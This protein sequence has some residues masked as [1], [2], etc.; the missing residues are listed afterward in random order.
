MY[1]FTDYDG[2]P[3]YLVIGMR[4][5]LWIW[6]VVSMQYNFDGD[7]PNVSQFTLNFT[8]IGSLYILCF[9]TVIAFSWLFPNYVRNKVIVIGSILAQILAF[10]Y[11]SKTFDTKGAFFKISNRSGSML[12]GKIT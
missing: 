8:I 6:F 2:I 5:L 3:G 10:Y 11:L 9:P 12:P 7:G 4:F 1:N